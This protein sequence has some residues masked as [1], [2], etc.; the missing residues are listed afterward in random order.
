MLWV[1]LHLHQIFMIIERIVVEVYSRKR[2]SLRIAD[3]VSR[4]LKNWASKWLRRLSNLTISHNPREAVVGACSTL[5]SY[6]YSI[7]LLTRPFL[8][9]EIYEYMGASLRSGGTRADH[10]EKRKYADAALDAASSLVESLMIVI[11][12]GLL[13]HRMPLIV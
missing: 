9:Y 3:Y 7:M 8:I 4:Q 13:P 6:Y 2:I 1:G 10:Q 11:K 5:C 12:T